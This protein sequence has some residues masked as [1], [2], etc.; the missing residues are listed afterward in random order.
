MARRRL[1]HCYYRQASAALSLPVLTQGQQECESRSYLWLLGMFLND[2]ANVNTSLARYSKA[3]DDALSQVGYAKRIEDDYGVLLGINRVMNAY[4][5]LAR[6]QDALPMIQEGLSVADLIKADP[7][8][9]AGLHMFAS[10]CHMA[11]G[12][13]M[14]ALD[15]QKEA[16]KLSLDVNN[17][18][19]VSRHYVHLGLAYHKLNNHS[20]A[21]RLIRESAEVGKRLRDEKLSSEIVA[22]SYV[23][24]G[25][26]YREIGDLD[27]AVK[28]YGDAL[29]LFDENDIDIQ[30][31]RFWA[32]KGILLT[33]IE[34]GDDSATEEELK[35]VLGLYEQYRQNIEDE[36]SRNN[37][38]DNEQGVY[39]IAIE[40][41]YFKRQDPRRAFD[42]SEMSRA[43]S[44]LDAVDLPQRKLLDENLTS[45]RLPRST[46]PL[47]LWQ[48]QGRLPGK[49][50]LLQY[51]VLDKHLITWVVSGTDFKSHS[52]EVGREEIDNKV[53]DYL[54]SLTSGQNV[55]HGGNYRARSSELYSLLIKPVMNL[56]DKDA[57]ICII[58]DKALN[59]LPFASL[60]SPDTGKYLI[61][62]QAILTSPSANMFLV[63]SDRAWQKEAVQTERL[64][65]VGNPW[66]DKAMFGD[67]KDLPWAAKQASEISA[68][69][70]NSTVFLEKNARE[71]DV[72]TEIEKSDVAHF[73]THY[74]ADER[75]P[76][77]S[78][79]PLAGEKNPASKENDGVLQ[80]FE[81]YNMN[82]SRLRLVVL[83]ACQ[84]GIERYYKGEGAIGLA[85]PFQSAGIP[86]VMASLW[87]VESYPTK[88]LMIAF[89]KH[90]KSDRLSTAQALRQAQLDMIR[91]G[92]TEFR[93]PYH[94]AA[95]TVVGGHANF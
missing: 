12:K 24:L 90:R 67:L 31:L 88:E 79:I 85:R 21:I 76:M 69:Y 95:Y 35:K 5:L 74:V 10:K 80:T 93:N 92:S 17:P 7:G 30:W 49:T 2:V 86:L 54:R 77:L 25:E 71:L 78:A 65:S 8:Q 55:A 82:L 83:S 43:R 81:F 1:G 15:Y 22:F 36:S 42:F 50:Q 23:H 66:F 70:Q 44:L 3:L 20:E 46:Q 52:V 94:W 16:L 59:R 89:H 45:V 58:P 11:A 68:F 72:R 27:N 61:E 48:I 9:L 91:S 26:V 62:E 84:T 53:S 19:Q 18:W 6:Y 56:L 29:R 32:K 33:Y 60:I 75:S 87:P 39:D 47:N 14:A 41:A 57:E 34:R 13:F 37:F 64:L 63:A 40:Y 4:I 38:F 51:S 73:A 28:S